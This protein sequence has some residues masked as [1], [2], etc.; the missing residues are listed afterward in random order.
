MSSSTTNARKLNDPRASSISE[1]PLR[2]AI[3]HVNGGGTDP[4]QWQDLT[5]SELTELLLHLPDC[6]PASVVDA[7]N[8]RLA[9]LVAAES[10]AATRMASLRSGSA[11]EIAV[12]VA[13][14]RN[15]TIVLIGVLG[16]LAGVVVLFLQ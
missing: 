14:R 5:A 3:R 2:R 16:L 9:D 15:D 11:R 7:I 10:A 1:A 8:A 6:T 13:G 4:A 12:A